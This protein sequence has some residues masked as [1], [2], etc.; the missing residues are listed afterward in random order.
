[1]TST[2]R[3]ALI[4]A[5]ALAPIVIGLA[6]PPPPPKLQGDLVPGSNRPYDPYAETVRTAFIRVWTNR[7]AV[8][9]AAA[10]LLHYDG[11]GSDIPVRLRLGPQDTEQLSF[12]RNSY[13][14]QD[15][16][17]QD[18]TVWTFSDDAVTDIK[19]GRFRDLLPS[20]RGAGWT[21]AV[22][23]APPAGWNQDSA[24]WRQQQPIALASDRP[25]CP[26]A[27]IVHDDRPLRIVDV[28][29]VTYRCDASSEQTFKGRLDLACPGERLEDRAAALAGRI[30]RVGDQLAV[31]ALS[32]SDACTI[33]VNGVSLAPGRLH[34]FP[35]TARLAVHGR[36][37]AASYHLFRP[38]AQAPERAL[39]WVDRSGRRQADP[40][41][42]TLAAALGTDIAQGMASG[43]GEPIKGNVVTTLDRDLQQRVQQEVKAWVDDLRAGASPEPGDPPAVAAVTIMNATTGAVLVLAGTDARGASLP[44]K[45]GDPNFQL[46]PVGSTMKP[47][48]ATAILT[49]YPQL[50]ATCINVKEKMTRSI[51]G[52]ALPGRLLT[53][54]GDGID[55]DRFLI[56]SNNAYMAAL[57]LLASPANGQ[58]PTRNVDFCG[59]NHPRTASIYEV[60]LRSGG[61]RENPVTIDV[62]PRWQ[63]RLSELF[64]LNAG[65]LTGPF[66]CPD[67]RTRSDRYR[68]FGP[69]RHLGAVATAFDAAAP[70][71]ENL[72]LNRQGALFESQILR[73]ALGN[74]DG[75]L[76]TIKLAEAYARLLTG[77]CVTATL[78]QPRD[79]R[80]PTEWSRQ[81]REAAAWVRKPMRDIARR[82][83]AW[84][85]VDHLQQDLERAGVGLEA[86]AKTGTPTLSTTIE[87]DLA[88]LRTLARRGR[89]AATGGTLAVENGPTLTESQA[90]TLTTLT[91]MRRR[92]PAIFRFAADDPRR[93]A[94]IVCRTPRC[95]L[96]QS[97]DSDSKAFVLG[98]E[99]TRDS[100]TIRYVVAVNLR[101][102][103]NK[104]MN[105]TGGRGARG[106]PAAA[107]GGAIARQ[108]GERIAAD[109]GSEPQ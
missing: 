45:V 104:Q 17:T 85:G 8:G 93:L 33:R 9:N 64:G 26:A 44:G 75:S 94:D 106:N 42:R 23:F 38:P 6:V 92:Q 35:A 108:L 37:E 15:L 39:S 41:V 40:D 34:A 22:L 102:R 11:P 97:P 4:A 3:L 57:I 83:D 36:G 99:T 77:T 65:D 12:V 76:T 74:F 49:E 109:F 84:N 81:G 86:Y 89:L 52:L 98:L 54:T 82:G 70:Q 88:A 21:G 62:K 13:L 43:R 10:S 90:A 50:H 27:N 29:T 2:R 30:L 72:H 73:T 100:A 71:R 61:F 25:T 14:R 79:N 55:F 53:A 32:R 58:P 48:V 66:A 28:D 105:W 68:D 101:M 60:A 91:R 46:L 78:S 5:L 80:N 59:N 51:L 18:P 69:W 1:M 96:K 7:T 20:R 107:L 63:E 87:E 24:G 19:P 95:G 103:W 56:D 47:L 16:R 67:D 31:V